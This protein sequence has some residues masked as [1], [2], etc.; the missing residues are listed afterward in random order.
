MRNP[1]ILAIR[2]ELAQH[3]VE[4]SD[5]EDGG[6]HLKLHYEWKGRT[7][8]HIVARTPSDGRAVKNAVGDV[9]RVLR[10]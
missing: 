7:H 8:T 10:G 9:R 4:D 2:A 5:L 1:I 6:R 3:G